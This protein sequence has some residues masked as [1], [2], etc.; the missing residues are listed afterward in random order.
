MV[1]MKFE[2]PISYTK[3]DKINFNRQDLCLLQLDTIQ[4]V[5]TYITA[6]YDTEFLTELLSRIGCSPQHFFFAFALL[7]QQ[8]F[9]SFIFRYCP[10]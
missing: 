7:Q 5:S 8:F 6:E 10:L 2:A 1:H 9:L 3:V 4:L